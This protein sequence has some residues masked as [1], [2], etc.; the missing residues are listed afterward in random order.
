L[1]IVRLYEVPG[2]VK[3][4][5]HTRPSAKDGLPADLFSRRLVTTLAGGVAGLLTLLPEHSLWVGY[6]LG[7]VA[8]GLF[9]IVMH[10]LLSEMFKHHPRSTLLAALAGA[11]SIVAVG[12][13]SGA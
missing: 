5:P 12:R 13:R 8:G 7:H 11:A 3:A 2:S 10:A 4:L 9:L 6:V 1:N